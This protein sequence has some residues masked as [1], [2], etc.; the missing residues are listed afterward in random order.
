MTKNKKRVRTSVKIIL[1]I[2]IPVF[3]LALALG[4][5]GVYVYY[6]FD[7]IL[8]S[9]S[10]DG[11]DV[12]WLTQE[13]AS[14]ML[15]LQTYDSRGKNAEV[16]VAFPDDS[17]LNVT[18]DDVRLTHNARAFVDAAFSRGRGNGFFRDT[19]AFLQ[20]TYDVHVL[21]DEPEQYEVSYTL[22]TS[23]L[24]IRV[25]VFTDNYNSLLEES[26]PLIYEDKI[27]IV[28][29]AGQ[30][31]ADEHKIYDMMLD[32]LLESLDGGYPVELSYDLPEA[33]ANVAELTA[34]RRSIIALPLSA[35]YDPE[36]KIISD[37]VVGVDI[38][39]YD[40]VA[41][42]NDTESGKTVTIDV[43][44]TDPEITRDY[45]ENLIFRDII[46]QCVT[47]IGGSANRLNNIIL[48][49]EAIDGLVLE[50]GEDFSFNHIVGRRTS[51]RGYKS[52]PAFSGGQTVQAIGGGICQVS[53]TI[54][55]AIKDTDIRVRER[56]AHGQPIS[57]LPRGRDATVSW[58]TL[59][60]KFINNTEYPLRIDIDIDGR[61]LTVQ[62]F[63][64]LP[65]IE[66]EFVEPSS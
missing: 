17:S 4:G 60:F 39:Y 24:R 53:S 26:A 46:G 8:P 9:V 7:G 40:A 52:A 50:P 28:K 64:T 57:Y 16:T 19:A 58:G 36:T 1:A 34:I 22:D 44:Y 5:L 49:S 55:S 31:R 61:T 65:E 56:H 30:V 12:S 47:Q 48:A 37:S 10:I 62:V 11:M 54:Y 42:L 20:R 18:G 15:N 13:E 14:R 41:L 38:N 66:N 23:S 32:G 45:L 63:G 6:Y 27:V 35:K 25:E 59:D 3:T 33:D 21:H 2:A 29:G 51:A 43:E